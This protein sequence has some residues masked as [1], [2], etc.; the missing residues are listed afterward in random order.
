MLTRRNLNLLGFLA[1]VGLLGFAIYVQGVLK[2]EP[3]PLCIFQRV[4]VAAC[5]VL[6]LLAWVHDPASWGARVYAALIMPAALATI[7]VAARHVWIQHLPDDA[8]PACGAGLG[9]LLQEFPLADVIRKVLTGSGECHQVNWVFL[10]LSMPAWVVLA[11]TGLGAL[12][13]W[14]NLAARRR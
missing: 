2:V 1:C 10:G 14:A 12:G 8:V 7:G 9:F 11:G 13:G 3:C 6:F 4:G 5:G